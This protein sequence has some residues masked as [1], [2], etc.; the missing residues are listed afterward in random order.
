M[1]ALDESISTRAMVRQSLK[2]ARHDANPDWISA[3]RALQE[4]LPMI[5]ESYHNYDTMVF[6]WRLPWSS[7]HFKTKETG[8]AFELGMTGLSLVLCLVRASEQALSSRDYKRSGHLL[9]QAESIAL[10]MTELSLETKVEDL[11]M[12]TFTS[13]VH[14]L[15]GLGHQ[16]LLKR[17]L[18]GYPENDI[19][20]ATAGLH[21][22]IAIHAVDEYRHCLQLVPKQLRPWCL[23]QVAYCLSMS[24]VLMAIE[25]SARRS[26]GK[27]LG[28]LEL[29]L[30]AAPKDDK[31]LLL[32]INRL[33]LQYK[34]DNQLV[35]FQPIPPASELAQLPSGRRVFQVKAWESDQQ[36]PSQG[37]NMF[38][39]GYY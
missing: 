20:A 10:Y 30:K 2:S 7:P 13:L 21:T 1:V 26:T 35:E 3:V 23:A 34:S 8:G 16:L 39:Q 11:S 5:A 28:H 37:S 9:R 12:A 19:S 15:D 31:S 36:I 17:L 18:D 14:L 25:S 24:H 32:L 29:A 33:T 4:Y 22:R 6:K 27:A 38:S